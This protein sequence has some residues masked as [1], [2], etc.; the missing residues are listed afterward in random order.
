MQR[1]IGVLALQGDFL[2]HRKVLSDLGCKVLTV[3]RS[4]HLNDCDGLIVPG[5]ESTTMNLLLQEYGFEPAIKRRVLEGMGIF[6][7][8]AGLIILAKTIKGI[9]QWSLRLLDIQVARN[10]YGRQTESFEADIELAFSESG[11]RAVF[12]RAPKI[13]KVGPSVEVLAGH[14]GEIVLVRQDRILGATFHPE[15]TK[16]G[17]IHRYFI[18][19]VLANKPSESLLEVPLEDSLDLHTFSPA[20]TKAVLLAY[21]GECLRAGLTEVRIIHGKGI[22][23]QRRIVH[24]VLQQHPRVTSFNEA[25]TEAG[26][27]GATLVRLTQ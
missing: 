11:F 5:G 6:G 2:E 26:G 12:I 14:D 20:E 25:P 1:T 19:E 22:G 16:D 8:C 18:D 21:L 17:R 27:W 23:T 15:L 24:S 10:A 3:K 13:V 9:E 7:T 4:E